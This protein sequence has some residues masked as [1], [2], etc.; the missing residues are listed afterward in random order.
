MQ[1]RTGPQPLLSISWYF[2]D[3]SVLFSLR[4]DRL[5]TW[6]WMSTGRTFSTSSSQ[7]EVIHAQ[8]QRGSNHMS[9]VIRSAVMTCLRKSRGDTSESFSAD[10]VPRPDPIVTW[11]TTYAFARHGRLRLTLEPG[12]RRR[13]WLEFAT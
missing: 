2:S 7:R 13:R 8:G 3:K 1:T 6:N 4:I 11:P 5:I 12:W 10:R 9:A